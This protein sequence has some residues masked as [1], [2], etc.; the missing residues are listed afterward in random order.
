[1]KYSEESNI[2]LQKLRTV[3]TDGSPAMV[4][5]QDGSVAMRQKDDFFSE[6]HILL[7]YGV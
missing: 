5:C 6:F 7:Q 1:M 2:P 4:G 3:R